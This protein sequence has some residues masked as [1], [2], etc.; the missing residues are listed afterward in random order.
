M[1]A[2]LIETQYSELTAAQKKL[3]LE[4]FLKEADVDNDGKISKK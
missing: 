3:R 2:K 1:I 4:Y